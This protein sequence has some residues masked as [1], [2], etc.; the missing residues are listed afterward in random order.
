MQCMNMFFGKLNWVWQK[1]LLARLKLTDK[2]D[3]SRILKLIVLMQSI[4]MYGDNVSIRNKSKI[5]NVKEK[6]KTLCTLF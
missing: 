1:N 2:W 3:I 4:S 6:E 5:S